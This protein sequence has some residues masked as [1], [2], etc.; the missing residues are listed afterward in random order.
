MQEGV[1]CFI[2][3]GWSDHGFAWPKT[4]LQ[5][6]NPS[7]KRWKAVLVREVRLG[8]LRQAPDYSLA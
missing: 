8:E 7:S 3:T 4:D 2:I 5:Y 6:L 1:K